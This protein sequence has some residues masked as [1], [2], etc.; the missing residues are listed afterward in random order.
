MGHIH[1]MQRIYMY[2]ITGIGSLPTS[3]HTTPDT[4]ERAQQQ[5]CKG[6]TVAKDILG[7]MGL[8]SFL[9]EIDLSRGFSWWVTP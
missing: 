8:G 3:I 2:N 6:K 9:K 5:K 7:S 1:E 4:T